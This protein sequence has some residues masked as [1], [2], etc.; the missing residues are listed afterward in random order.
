MFRFS[1]MWSCLSRKFVSAR[2]ARVVV[3]L[4][5]SMESNLAVMPKSAVEAKKSAA[6]MPSEDQSRMW[7]IATSSGCASSC[8]E[9]GCWRSSAGQAAVKCSTRGDDIAEAGAAQSERR[10][11]RLECVSW[12]ETREQWQG[13]ALSDA[14]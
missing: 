3:T 12:N 2:C 9:R 4:N 1:Q 7:Y 8:R 13:G 11:G 10:L 5:T 6:A 14:A